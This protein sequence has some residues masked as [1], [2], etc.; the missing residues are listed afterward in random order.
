MKTLTPAQTAYHKQLIK[1]FHTLLSKMPER[2]QAK[3]EILLSYNVTSSTFL[4][5]DQL[6]KACD[7]LDA[8]LNPRVRS[9]DQWR[10][11][12]MAAIGGWLRS[13]N[14]KESVAIIQA[15]ACRAAQSKSFNQIPEQKL[16]SLYNAFLNK[17]KS[18]KSVDMLTA[19]EIDYLSISN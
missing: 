1:R 11:R 2:Q 4:S 6:K 16:I 3:E 17:A 18:I 19:E 5:I 7:N 12:L 13:L 14:K 9:N 10:K 8:V 15:I